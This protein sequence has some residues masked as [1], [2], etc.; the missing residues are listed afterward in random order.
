MDNITTYFKIEKETLDA[1]QNFTA[2]TNSTQNIVVTSKSFTGLNAMKLFL[3]LMAIAGN[4]LIILCVIQYRSLRTITNLLIAN[5]AVADF[6]NGCS[7]VI[8]STIALLHCVR[9]AAGSLP[10]SSASSFLTLFLFLANN[11]AVLLIALE[12]FIC[13]H[14]ALRYYTVLTFRRMAFTVS[15]TWILCVVCFTAPMEQVRTVIIPL[16][17]FLCMIVT[18]SL[19]CY[20]G[21]V[22]CKKLRE[23]APQPQ[24]QVMDGTTAESLDNQ[25][26]QWKITKFL[27]FVLGVYSGSLLL[28]TIVLGFIFNGNMDSCNSIP[29]PAFFA[30]G[31]WGFNNCVNAFLYAWKS[32]KFRTSI[33]RRLGIK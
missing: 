33:K 30:I 14:F 27:A 3:G 25:N 23:V 4:S 18:V 16:G 17:S 28:S 8:L 6:L 32:E 11:F 20:V 13:I 5:L 19:H 2:G 9:N 12:R 10:A 29:L 7:W 31:I 24:P 22:A 21:F 26:A 1:M 15:L